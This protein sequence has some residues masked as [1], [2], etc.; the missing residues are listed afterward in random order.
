MTDKSKNVT[1]EEENPKY[2]CKSYDD[3][4]DIET[5]CIT[6]DD[7][8]KIARFSCDLKDDCFGVSWSSTKGIIKLCKDLNM[9]ERNDSSFKS[10]MKSSNCNSVT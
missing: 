2:E 4:K 10:R 3:V 7:C 9:K 8:L 5:G 1:Y 6:D